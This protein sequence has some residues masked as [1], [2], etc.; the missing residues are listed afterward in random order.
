MR[1]AGLISMSVD[2]RHRRVRLRAGDLGE[3]FPCLGE[4]LP[5]LGECLPCLLDPILHPAAAES[6]AKA[7]DAAGTMPGRS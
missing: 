7:P 6:P 4:C 3:Y 2:G 5:C 1:E